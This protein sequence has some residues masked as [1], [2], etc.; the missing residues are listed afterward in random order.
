MKTPIP[1][2]Y[3]H[4]IKAFLV[5]FTLTAPF[6]LVDQMR[7]ATPFASA[8]LAFALFG[9]DEIAVEIEEPFGRDAN[10]LPLDA[11]GATIARDVADI[12]RHFMMVKDSM[13]L[14][15]VGR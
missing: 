11:V 12:G 10:D 8:L 15:S 4:H 5:V 13:A 14:P 2:A 1:F 9:I 7:W 6:A 3:A